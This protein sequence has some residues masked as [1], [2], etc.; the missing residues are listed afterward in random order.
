MVKSRSVIA[1]P[2]GATIKEQ[3]A[4]RQMSQKEFAVRMDMSEKHISRLINGNV[5]LTTDMAVRLETVLGIPAGFWCNLEAIYREKLLRAEAENEMDADMDIAEKFPYEKMAENGWIPKTDDLKERVFHLRKYFELVRLELL[6]DSAVNPVACYART[7]AETDRYTLLAWAQKAKLE[8]RCRSV[9]N[10]DIQG[11][12]DDLLLEISMIRE[13]KTGDF[14]LML[15][16][17]LATHGVI[18]IFLPLLGNSSLRG[19]SFRDGKKVIMGLANYEEDKSDFWFCFFH[20]LAHILFG[21]IDKTTGVSEED[22]AKADAF[23]NKIIKNNCLSG[24]KII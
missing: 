8:A 11:I 1:T 2:P 21:H 18:L 20:E 4:D 13:Q 9:G 15:T 22:E 5:L 7:T 17:R 24:E 6:Q 19:V 3:L 23:A 14:G 10:L 12:Y 16:E